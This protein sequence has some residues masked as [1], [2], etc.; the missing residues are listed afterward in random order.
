MRDENCETHA[1]V[2]AMT[3]TGKFTMTHIEILAASL[4]AAN[5]AD[6]PYGS[7][8]F[9]LRRLLCIDRAMRLVTVVHPTQCATFAVRC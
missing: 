9:Q 1:K 5:H 7:P 8:A 4:H 6:D 2:W 3:V